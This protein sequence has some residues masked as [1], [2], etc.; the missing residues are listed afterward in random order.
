ML[1][2]GL[3]ASVALADQRASR[4][5][6]GLLKTFQAALGISEDEVAQIIDVVEQGGSLAEALG[7]PLERLYAEVMVLVL[8]A[9][10]VV[11]GAESR[12]LVESF[13][14]D[15]LFHEVS[16]E[17]AQT[18]I[19]EAVAALSSEGLPQRLAVLAHGLSTHGQRLKAYELAMK[20]A[21][22]SGH[23][24]EPE[25]WI[26]DLLQATFGIADDEVQK[27]TRETG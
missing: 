21:H 25:Q 15:P 12:A 16:P 14:S 1:A 27:L 18:F 23:A 6:L 4:L 11:K 22:S 3:A 8:A 19:S 13:A 20:I 10:G 5:E 24:S 26:L 9:D 2:F 7:E 17:R